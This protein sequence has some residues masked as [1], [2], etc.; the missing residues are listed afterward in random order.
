MSSQ[1]VNG[2]KKL[3]LQSDPFSLHLGYG[4]TVKECCFYM[5]LSDTF[6]A[7]SMC[8]FKPNEVHSAAA[9]FIQVQMVSS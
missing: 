6:P 8:V 9:F 5:F 1:R 2:K 4:Q 3:L 7:A